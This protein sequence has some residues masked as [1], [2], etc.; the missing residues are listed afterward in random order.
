MAQFAT[1]RVVYNGQLDPG[2]ASA[3]VMLTVGDE[4]PPETT[5]E[6]KPCP[7]RKLRVLDPAGKAVDELSLAVGPVLSD[8]LADPCVITESC[9]NGF[10]ELAGLPDGDYVVR[11]L[12][13]KDRRTVVRLTA[14]IDS[15]VLPWL[16]N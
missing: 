11:D 10:I 15:I 5:L 1:Q 7:L 14:D 2:F 9:R 4:A 3:F 8:G 6:A 16:A 13:K 12:F